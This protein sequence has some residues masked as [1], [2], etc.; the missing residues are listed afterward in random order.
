VA[1][2]E[3]EILIAVD[4]SR[5]KISSSNT[6]SDLST[7]PRILTEIIKI[8]KIILVGVREFKVVGISVEINLMEMISNK[9]TVDAVEDITAVKL[10]KVL[11]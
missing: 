4:S 7:I 10:I 1:V 2:E 6:N 9:I 8:L 3:V 11:Y 5:I